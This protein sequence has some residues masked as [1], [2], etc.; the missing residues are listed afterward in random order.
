MGHA[1]ALLA[2]PDAQEQRL[3]FE[4]IAEEKLTVRD[5]EGLLGE[6]EVSGAPATG[7][8]KGKKAR[9]KTKKPHILSLE[10]RFAER[11]GTRVR[12]HER[13]GRGRIT[14]DFYS[15]EE[16]ERIREAIL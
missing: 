16:F 2:I 7:E 6:K 12:I 11:L 14:I 10:E 4:R 3:Y 8:R 9:P 5:L 1:K 15:P 13:N